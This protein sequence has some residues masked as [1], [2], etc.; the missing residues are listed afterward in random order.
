MSYDYGV[1]CEPV[2]PDYT[3]DPD[4]TTDF[5]FN[6]KP[7]LD[8][9]TIQSATFSLPDG[10]TSVSESNTT[11][12]A[13]IFVSGGSTGCTYRIRCRIVTDGGRTWDKTLYILIQER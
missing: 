2:V 4:S 7:E 12:T 8:G 5:E 13:T 11:T 6:W 1:N 3:K 9:D 10:M